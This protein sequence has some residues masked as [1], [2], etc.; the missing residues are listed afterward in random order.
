LTLDPGDNI[1][2]VWS[3]DGARVAFTTYRKGNAD[4]YVKNANGV[5]A[6]T[7]ILES[8][9]DEI[10]ED[11]SKDGRYIAYL[12]GQD[13]HKDIYAVPLSG[14]KK[15][16]PLVQGRYQKNEPQF[17]YDGKWLAY[18][19]EESGAFQVY[20]ISFPALDQKL[21]VSMAG[22]GQPRWRRDGKEL[23]YRAPDNR[24]MVVDIQAEPR[25]EA[26]PPRVLFPPSVNAAMTRDP[27]RH[28]LAVT[29]DGD[30]F[31]MRVPQG[32]PGTTTGPSA[33]PQAP[34]QIAVSQGQ[35]AAFAGSPIFNGLT[36]VRGW[37]AA[38][39][40]ADK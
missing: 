39:G 9:S 7:P 28:Q 33:V 38:L 21:Q 30:R 40:K 11:W 14:D 31:L 25:L 17:S 23:Y 10:V 6:E 32:S 22:G 20:V 27:A 34:A 16:V 8:S 36:V 37:T 1:N 29:P 3:P 4:I 13:N 12:F 19:S 15:P 2:P 26:G 18:T 35:P 24:I 5:G